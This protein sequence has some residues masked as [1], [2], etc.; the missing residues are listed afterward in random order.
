MVSRS[1]FSVDEYYIN[2]Q[3]KLKK[4]EIKNLVCGSDNWGNIV[5]I[6]ILQTWDNLQ[7]NANTY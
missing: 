1:Y 4:S 2:L 7:K 6:K 3:Q 5:F